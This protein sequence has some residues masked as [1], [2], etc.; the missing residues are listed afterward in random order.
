MI[1]ISGLPAL[2]WYH[3]YFLSLAYIHC[4][5]STEC[6]HLASIFIDEKLR[7]KQLH[8]FVKIYFMTTLFRVEFFI[9]LY[10]DEQ[11]I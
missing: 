4:T 5:S 6:L 1:S 7:A 2:L 8:V 9:L 3:E 11:N 10:S